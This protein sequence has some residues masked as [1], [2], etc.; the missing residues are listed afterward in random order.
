MHVSAVAIAAR[1]FH[2]D[3]VSETRI[4]FLFLSGF[5]FLYCNAAK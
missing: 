3:A 2:G 4:E 5:S 1:N